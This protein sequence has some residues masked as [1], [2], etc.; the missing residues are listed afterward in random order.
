[1]SAMT[2]TPIPWAAASRPPTSSPPSSPLVQ[3]LMPMPMPKRMLMMAWSCPVP[4]PTLPRRS[5]E[6]F[7]DEGKVTGGTARGRRGE[8]FHQCLS[9]NVRRVSC[10]NTTAILESALAPSRLLARESPLARPCHRLEIG[11]RVGDG[12]K[13]PPNTTVRVR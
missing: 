6:T 8:G 3:V 1:M 13:A 10:S 11:G 5:R 9:G 12:D 4:A 7:A 2:P